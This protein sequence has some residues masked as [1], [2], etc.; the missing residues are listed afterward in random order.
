MC[1]NNDDIDVIVSYGDDDIDVIVSYG[2][3]DIDVIVS[4][5]EDDIDV[6]VSYGYDDIDS[7]VSC[8][9]VSVSL[10]KVYYDVIVFCFDDNDDFNVSSYVEN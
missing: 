9:N 5:V 3:D 2:E 10:D 1:D 8:D 6:I 7:V 4:Y